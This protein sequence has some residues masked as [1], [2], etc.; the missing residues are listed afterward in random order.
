MTNG[1]PWDTVMNIVF[2][3]VGFVIGLIQLWQA[4]KYYLAEQQAKF[5][6]INSAISQIAQRLAVIE[7]V[8][9]RLIDI[10]RTLTALGAT[11]NSFQERLFGIVEQR[12]I[13][14]EQTGQA[15]VEASDQIKELVV[16]ELTNSSV[17]TTESMARLEEKIDRV[18]SDLSKQVVNLAQA[19]TPSVIS[20]ES[21]QLGQ[22]DVQGQ[23]AVNERQAII[24][25]GSFRFERQTERLWRDGEEVPL[26]ALEVRLL[27][28]LTDNEN[29]ITPVGEI[30]AAVYGISADFASKYDNPLI[31]TLIARLRSKV[32]PDAK[33]IRT[34][35]GRGFLFT[36][37]DS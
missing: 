24:Q 1:F 18:V 37:K 23:Q 19:T 12:F 33:Y 26:T 13:V 6:Q 29:R 35:R 17:V 11:S 5:E 15:A 34:V 21:I 3:A 22:S 20:T 30:L 27:A 25:F 14:G 4:Q 28:F 8:T 2:F 7:G 9:N 16:Q 31:Y 10:D 36:S 32:D